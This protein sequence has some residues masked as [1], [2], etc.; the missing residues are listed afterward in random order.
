MKRRF[1]PAFTLIE[2]MIVIT[3]ISILA[4]I[5][6]IGATSVQRSTRDDARQSQSTV[7]A[8]ALEKYYE[9]NNEYPSVASI[10][11]QSINDVKQKLAIKDSEVLTF[12]TVTAGTSA[13][14]ASNPTP[15]RLT[16]VAN[17]VDSNAN[18]QCQTS[19]NGYCDAFALQYVK[20]VDNNTVTIN[21]RHNAVYAVTDPNGPVVLS[22]PTQPAVV[23][24]QVNSSLVRFTA[25]SA[26]CSI[27]S[28]EYKIRYNTSSSSISSMPD[29][30]T[31]NWGAA[32]T[33]DI[34]PGSSTVFYSQSLARCVSGADSSADS[35]PSTVDTLNFTPA[36][37]AGTAPSAPVVTASATSTSSISVSW[38]PSSGS[39]TITYTVRYGTSSG[40]YGSTA[41]DCSAI[42]TTSCSIS[43]LSASTTYYVQV[44]ATNSVASAAGTTNA[45]TSAVSASCSSAPSAPAGFYNSSVTTSSATVSWSSSSIPANCNTPT[46]TFKYGTSS[47]SYPSQLC[48]GTT[49]TSCSM[50][51][52]SAGTTYYVQVL[53]TNSYTSSYGYTTVTTSS[54]APTCST[55]PSSPVVSAA[56]TSYSALRIDW[57]A[58]STPT[59]CTAPTYTVRYGTSSPSTVVC[60]GT[61]ALTCDITGLTVNTT[62]QISVTPANGYNSGT[63]GTTSGKTSTYTLSITNAAITIYGKLRIDF[64]YNGDKY[65]SNTPTACAISG[66]APN[67]VCVGDVATCS[68]NQSVSLSDGY[69]ASATATAQGVSAP[70]GSPT[71]SGL[72]KVSGG[73]NISWDASNFPNA[74]YFRQRVYLQPGGT[75]AW[76]N[77]SQVTGTQPPAQVRGLSNGTYRFSV[78]AANC[79]GIG[80]IGSRSDITL[81]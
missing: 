13:L 17:T 4:S 37:P 40:T 76:S 65:V 22:P 26:S 12:P 34:N 9:N 68:N 36:P 56:A 77:G 8:E 64:S 15:A 52:L 74:S 2:L 47:G 72:S 59:N 10:T 55:V 62:Y 49:S 53:A 19:M 6:I 51:G 48:T 31:V 57:S 1:Q 61:S 33:K 81:P 29:W 58:S 24:S 28:V 38:Q 46:Y 21:S 50:T 70:S 32:T 63:A 23:G 42:S 78:W 66:S 73:F 30:S 44:T 80:P 75:E 54:P 27:G 7:V 60:S 69:G 11:N 25:S 18:A 39:A 35:T 41:A 45:T 16:Y 5:S 43:G 14:V 71:P 20:E 79:A 67:Y 3:I